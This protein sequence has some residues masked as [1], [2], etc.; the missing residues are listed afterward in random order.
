MSGHADGANS[1]DLSII[2]PVWNERRK[3]GS[4][5]RAAAEFCQRH[6]RRAEILVADDGSNDGTAEAAEACAPLAGCE[7]RVLPLSPHRG[8]GHAV[9]QGMIASR[10]RLILFM[11]SGGCIAWEEIQRGIHLIESGACRIAHASRRL[12]GSRILRPQ[13][14]PRRVCAFLFRHLLA[15]LLGLPRTLTDTQAG[16][17]L[18]A[19]ETG[20]WLYAACSTDGFLFDAEIILRA[21]QVGLVI[22]EFPVSWR[23]DPDSRLR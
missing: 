4:D 2:I 18:Y 17:K 15:R 22:R 21:Q 7:L 14:L 16:L 23:A 12:P 10:G 11:D 1:V 5:I 8:K 20:R 13:S 3:I 19:G 6:G 9:R